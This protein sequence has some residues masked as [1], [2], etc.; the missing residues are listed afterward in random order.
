MLELVDRAGLSETIHVE[1][2]GTGDWHVG[3]PADPRACAHAETRG[4][5]LTG[6]AQQF[7]PAL[8]A[9][10]DYILA[11]DR[12]NYRALLNLA[13]DAASRKKVQLLRD[14]DPRGEEGLEVPDPYHGG[15]DGFREVFDMCFACCE[16][17]LAHVRR[18]HQL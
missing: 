7:T 17:L 15:E 13:P 1:S 11:A 12:S 18:E 6:V 8:F 3:E 4:L 14:Y 10:Y 9:R 2:A 5:K 16:Q